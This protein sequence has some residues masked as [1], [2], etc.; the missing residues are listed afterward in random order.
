VL[1]AGEARHEGKHDESHGAP[2]AIS[3]QRVGRDGG[4]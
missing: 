3:R 1:G 2:A 4:N